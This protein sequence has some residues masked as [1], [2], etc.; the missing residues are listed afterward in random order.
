MLKT[1][2]ESNVSICDLRDLVL[3]FEKLGAYED[4]SL[5]RKKI[6]DMRMLAFGDD[7]WLSGNSRHEHNKDQEITLN[8]QENSDKT[9]SVN[10]EITLNQESKQRENSG[11]EQDKTGR[12]I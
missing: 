2:D 7:G 5:V 3:L 6:A 1:V 8:V 11:F 12:L 9:L 4:A 10:Q